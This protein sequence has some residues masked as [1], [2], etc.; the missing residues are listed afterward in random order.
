MQYLRKE[1]LPKAALTMLA[2]LFVVVG[3]WSTSADC[4]CYTSITPAQAKNMIDNGTLQV[5]VDVRELTEFCYEGTPPPP[6]GHIPG[7]LNYPWSSGYLQAHYQELP[8]DKNILI[9]CGVGGRSANASAFLCGKGYPSVYNMLGGIKAWPYATEL[10]CE[11]SAEC[12]DGLYCNGT[13]TCVALE[14]V[15]SGDPCMQQ[16]KQCDEATDMCMACTSD[17]DCDNETDL[18]DNCVVIP[19]SRDLGTCVK[20]VVGVMIGT[21]IA[22]TDNSTCTDG[23]VCEK[24]QEDMNADTIGDACECYADY[25]N[26]GDV[27]LTDLA[28]LKGEFG[29]TNC[30][31]VPC[32]TDFNSN[33]K[34]NLS[35]LVIMKSQFGKTGCPMP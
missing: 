9:Y 26:D 8:A 28:K 17:A 7:A 2:A 12:E 15:H 32:L 31:T 10:C 3:L 13:E 21:G 1:T 5:I 19:N 23:A 25:N 14:C 27:N 20:P 35:D 29:R 30:A 24:N 6:P 18:D 33:N 34:V 22:C 11:S 4:Q 16:Y